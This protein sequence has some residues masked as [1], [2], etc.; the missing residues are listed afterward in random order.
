MMPQ[1]TMIYLK[2]LLSKQRIIT[3]FSSIIFGFLAHTF[4][5]VNYLPNWDGINNLYD[6]QNTIHLGRCFLTLA[7]GISSY[8]D[9]PWINGLLS[10]LYI[11]ISSVL[12]AELLQIKK[13]STRI[14]LSGL[15]VAFPVITATFGYMYTADGYFL[16]MLCMT[17]SIFVTLRYKTGFLAGALF[18]AFGFGC[19]QAYITFA[20]MLVITYSIK[21]LLYD[22][23][24]AKE[25]ITNF[26]HCILCLGIGL[27]IYSILNRFLLRA[28]GRFL[29]DY[30]GIG[31]FSLTFELFFNIFSSVKQCLIDFIYFFTGSL[32]HMNLY[33]Y[34]NIIMLLILVISYFIVKIGR[35]HV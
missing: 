15:L 20:I 7:C 8:F 25:C 23:S 18:A 16:S 24:S 2:K 3:F 14:F 17:L 5:F 34:L 32:S 27:I 26:L 21:H 35:A 6:S 9:L 28:E 10:L 33:S 30:Q 4:I 29:S 19:Y 13:T 11:G 1:A 31:N 22:N 12:I